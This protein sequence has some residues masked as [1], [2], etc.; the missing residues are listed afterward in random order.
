MTE[1]LQVFRKNDKDFYSLENVFSTIR[2]YLDSRVEVNKYNVPERK[3]NLG[4][5]CKNLFNL[6]KQK[7]KVFHI[8]GDI[9]YSVF[10]FP[11]AKTILTIHDCVFL[12]NPSPIKRWIF[13]KIWLQW[14]VRYSRFITTI[15]EASRRDIM[16]HTNCDEKK[17]IVIP[18]PLNE[19]FAYAEKPFNKIKPVIL[20]VGTWPNKNLERVAV[21]LEGLSCH[22]SIIGKLSQ[23][24][25]ELLQ[26][27]KIEY[28][29]RFQITETELIN[30]YKACDLVLFATT[31]EGFGLPV[32]EAQSI[33]RALITSNLSPMKE[34]AGKGACLVDPYQISGIREGVNKVIEDDAFRDQIIR[35]G[36]ENVKRYNPERVAA[37]YLSLYNQ[38]LSEN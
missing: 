4:A 32:I 18:D 10:A 20:Q 19:H 29:N 3:A 31:F 11:R 34:V 37:Q 5:I 16:V 28:T 33:G 26:Q 13:K 8:T 22:L 24:Q 9:H 25:K 7:A 12:K 30:E 23:D 6:R 21:A 1:V 2:P 15:S 36:R 27:R 14:P 38:I 17:I 35:D